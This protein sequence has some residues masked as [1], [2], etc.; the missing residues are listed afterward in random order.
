MPVTKLPCFCKLCRG[1]ADWGRRRLGAPDAQQ[2][3]SQD[4]Q[5]IVSTKYCQVSTFASKGLAAERIQA[6]PAMAA[7]LSALVKIYLA[8]C[9]FGMNR[10]GSGTC[11]ITPIAY[12]A[13]VPEL[14]CTREWHGT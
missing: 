1:A 8:L 6:D 14:T 7:F 3:L 10:F 12:A 4:F 9:I 11:S 2:P 13:D 5:D